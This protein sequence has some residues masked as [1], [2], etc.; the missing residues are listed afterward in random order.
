[1]RCNCGITVSRHN[2]ARHMTTNYHHRNRGRYV[3]KEKQYD[4]EKEILCKCGIVINKYK[5]RRHLKTN[6]HWN[7][8]E[9]Q[10]NIRDNALNLT[11][12]DDETLSDSDTSGPID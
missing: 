7:N 3:E 11:T 1:M 12:K 4:P 8:I 10:K 9:E 5:Y 6:K 2:I